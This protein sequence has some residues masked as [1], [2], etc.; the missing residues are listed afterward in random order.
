MWPSDG[1][2]QAARQLPAPTVACPV[3]LCMQ[4][5]AAGSDRAKKAAQRK[6]DQARQRVEK[7][8]Q[9]LKEAASHQVRG[10]VGCRQCGHGGALAG[11]I[12]PAPSLAPP[13]H[14]H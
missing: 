11:C 14:L 8:E 4:L 9:R 2:R 13:A 6:A 5:A 1:A 3:L 10:G 7:Y 12:E